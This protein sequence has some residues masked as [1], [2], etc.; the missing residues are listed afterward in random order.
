MR[1]FA[2]ACLLVIAC[3]PGVD[4]DELCAGLGLVRA[5][6]GDRCVCPE[7]TIT[8]EG[9]CELADGGFIAFPDGGVSSTEDAGTEPCET[10][11][12]EACDGPSEG[13]C[14]PGTRTCRDGVWS[15]CEGVVAASPETCNGV[16]DDCDGT[17]D[18]AVAVA[19]CARASRVDEAACSAGTCVITACDDGYED[20]DTDPSTG[21]EVELATSVVHCG[22]CGVVCEFG[23]GCFD[24]ECAPRATV[25][26]ALEITADQI[27]AWDVAAIPGGVGFVATVSGASVRVGSTLVPN[28]GLGVGSGTDSLVGVVNDDGTLR[29]VKRVG[30]RDPDGFS[31]LAATESLLVAAGPLEGIGDY[32]DGRFE[33]SEYLYGPSSALVAYDVASG[34]LRYATRRSGTFP[35]ALAV[36]GVSGTLCFAIGSSR[37]G[38]SLEML[39]ATDLSSDVSN[40]YRGQRWSRSHPTAT[41]T[42]AR[43]R[44]ANCVF[45]LSFTGSTDFGAGSVAADGMDGA[46]VSYDSAGTL[47]TL[48][49][50]SA[51]GAQIYYQPEPTILFATDR[52]AALR[53]ISV[54]RGAYVQQRAGSMV[55]WTTP[56]DYG[57]RLLVA[58]RATDAGAHVV[59]GITQ[60]GELRVAGNLILTSTGDAVLVWLN[61]SDGSPAGFDRWTASTESAV[62]IKTTARSGQVFSLSFVAGTASLSG[63]TWG[64]V[65]GQSLV[66]ARHNLR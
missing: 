51:A 61:S 44:T 2:L 43:V 38:S 28:G 18:G 53:E 59:I 15:A 23:E 52:P 4:G 9:G 25:E 31:I 34:A 64:R 7:G 10:G 62:V 8:V 56:I 3:G 24:G 41:A 54:E 58:P 37:E 22:D 50:Q 42:S 48:E 65:G 30:S 47:Q 57:T 13:V 36:D 14:D 60:L 21:C 35:R 33:R 55:R 63:D 26:W 29:W 20:C 6:T 45:S 27:T 5:P 49:H 11:A 39:D 19:A 1:R 40:D 17:A 16:D 46:I 32:H 66:L 12:S